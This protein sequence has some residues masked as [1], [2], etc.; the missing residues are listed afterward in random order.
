[1]S[2]HGDGDGAGSFPHLFGSA[3]REGLADRRGHRRRM[4]TIC[5]I[6]RAAAI[7]RA[8]GVVGF[9]TETVYGLGADATNAEAVRKIFAA[10][11]RPS[12]NPLICHVPDADV[13]KRYAATWPAE[14]TRLAD[15]S[16]PGPLTLVL[17]K[18]ASI[19]DE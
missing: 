18:A 19:V 1:M 16:W 10:K 4:R 3:G 9:P 12:T 2:L 13:A 6:D 11:G 17:P 14:A 7:L 8:G 5:D 15:A